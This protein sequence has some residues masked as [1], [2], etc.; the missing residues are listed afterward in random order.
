ML[1]M[2][3]HYVMMKT[4]TCNHKLIFVE[5]LIC[6]KCGRVFS[7]EEAE[8]IEKGSREIIKSVDS[9]EL[10]P[11]YKTPLWQCG[12][13]SIEGYKHEKSKGNRDDISII[14]NIANKLQ[15]PSHIAQEFLALYKSLVKDKKDKVLAAKIGLLLLIIERKELALRIRRAL[16]FMKDKE[17]VSDYECYEYISTVISKQFAREDPEGDIIKLLPYLKRLNVARRY[18]AVK[19]LRLLSINVKRCL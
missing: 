1:D 2:I 15:L 11:H 8:E 12:L 17:R 5:E 6:C 7:E 10:D 3:Q 19:A 16:E 14:S 18:G 13:G 9:I 4:D